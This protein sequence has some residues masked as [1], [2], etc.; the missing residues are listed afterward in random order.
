MLKFT[1]PTAA[2]NSGNQPIAEIVSIAAWSPETIQK[3][4]RISKS[5]M[6]RE[7]F[8]IIALGVIVCLCFT[9]CNSPKKQGDVLGKKYCDCQKEYAKDMEKVYDDFLAKFDSYKFQ[10]RPEAC[11][12][13][14]GRSFRQVL[15]ICLIPNFLKNI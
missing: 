3:T 9:N 7:N 4:G 5:Q 15:K 13:W 10:T 1:K 14:Q 2:A 12:K 6:S 8:L 11:Q